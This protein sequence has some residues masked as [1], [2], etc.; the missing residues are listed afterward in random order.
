MGVDVSEY[1]LYG[2]SGEGD[3]FR[4]KDESDEDTKF[5]LDD[6]DAEEFDCE[7]ITDGYNNEFSILGINIFSQ[8]KNEFAKNVLE[9]EKKFKKLA[10]KYN[11]DLTEYEPS[12]MLDY[13]YW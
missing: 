13:Y 7:I 12:F 5:A 6:E 9:A 3:D 10:E 8:D 2:I 4:F 11:I 1:L